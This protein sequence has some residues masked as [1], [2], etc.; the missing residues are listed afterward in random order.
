RVE[1]NPEHLP[2]TAELLERAP[3]PATGVKHARARRLRQPVELGPDD[4][5]SPAV[6]P[7]SVVEFQHRVHQAFVHIQESLGGASLRS[8]SMGPVPPGIPAPAAATSPPAAPLPARLPPA[9][10][11]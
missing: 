10:A 5:P 4:P 6:P 9:A 7:V 11:E 2:V 3:R 1:L 8:A